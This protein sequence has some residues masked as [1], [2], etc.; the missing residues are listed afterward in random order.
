LEHLFVFIVRAVFNG[1]GVVTLTDFT[2]FLLLGLLLP[3]CIFRKLWQGRRVGDILYNIILQYTTN[4]STTTPGKSVL[5]V[6]I[7]DY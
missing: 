6:F 7:H 5:R 4:V 2:A 3:L 1:D